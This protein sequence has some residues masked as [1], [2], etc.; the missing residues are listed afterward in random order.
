M[1]YN[2]H[3]NLTRITNRDDVD[4]KHFYDSLAL[5][6]TLDLS[7][8]KTLY[9]MGS[10][11]GFPSIPLKLI[12]PH[13]EITIIDSLGKRIAFLKQLIETLDLKDIHLVYDRIE[14][15]AKSH[16]QACDVVIARALGR[17]PMILEM[18]IPMLKVDGRFVAYKG[19]HYKEELNESQQAMKR[20]ETTLEHIVSY[21]LPKDMGHHVHL[22]FVKKQH[23]SGY[24]RQ[25]AVMKKKPL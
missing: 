4:I 3:T 2:E 23:V 16:Q 5:A 6:K 22:V 8:V 12:Y 9:D 15:H 10:G 24:P 21:D 20:L 18:G 25:F 17:L 13:L 19:H 14:T 1:T 11:A 7:Q